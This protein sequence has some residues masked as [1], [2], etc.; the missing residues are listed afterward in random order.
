MTIS[1]ISGECLFNYIQDFPDSAQKLEELR[2]TIDN[3]EQQVELI[4]SLSVEI[5]NRLLH[6]S[7]PT[8]T[9]I[10]QYINAIKSL[11]L[12]DPTGVI[13]AQ[14]SKPIRRYLSRRPDT[15]SEIIRMIFDSDDEQL[16]NDLRRD[17][18]V[19]LEA[20]LELEVDYTD[21]VWQPQPRHAK[22]KP[23]KNASDVFN[24]LINIY[25]STDVFLKEIEKFLG[26]QLILSP[27]NNYEV[28]SQ[29]SIVEMLK[30]RFGESALTTC[31]I[32]LHDVGDS[33]RIFQ[34]ILNQQLPESECQLRVLLQSHMYWPSDTQS[35]DATFQLPSSMLSILEQFKSHYQKL[36][37]MRKVE[38]TFCN[39]T[40]DIDIDIDGIRV[41]KTV[42]PL[43][44]AVIYS[45]VSQERWTEDEMMDSLKCSK[46]SLRSALKYWQTQSLLEFD[47]N[48][49]IY[50]LVNIYA[51]PEDHTSD[52][53]DSDDDGNQT[54]RDQNDQSQKLADSDGMQQF[55]SYIMGMLTNLGCMNVDKMQM[56]LSMFVTTP[57]KYDRTVQQLKLHL[58]KLVAENKL[59]CGPDGYK[60]KK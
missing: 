30:L 12:L 59:D 35:D 40:L 51:A 41:Q 3:Q 25:P 8:A 56:M 2:P 34:S 10:E 21:P 48:L 16:A 15:V 38:F 19:Q 13:L 29:L 28:D 27:H 17:H 5:Y 9:V 11:L 58:D 44:A 7:V 4:R 6:V 14:V 26:D 24:S 18:L 43:Q 45:F 54:F 42:S 39:D 46:D 1:D 33:R 20:E 57:H 50:N 31:E 55:D 22:F 37:N 60:H 49:N 53:D 32:M 36:K 23:I 47:Q 52:S